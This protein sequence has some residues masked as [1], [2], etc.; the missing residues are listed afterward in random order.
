MVTAPCTRRPSRGEASR[1]STGRGEAGAHEPGP[2]WRRPPRPPGRVGPVGLRASSPPRAE[3]ARPARR[4]GGRQAPKWPGRRARPVKERRACGRHSLC[5]LCTYTTAPRRPWREGREA[6]GAEGGRG[7]GR[8]DGG[9]AA[10]KAPRLRLAPPWAGPKRG[11]ARSAPG[12]LPGRLAWG[13]RGA[14]PGAT[15]GRGP[16]PAGVSTPAAAENS[17]REVFAYGG[18]QG[19]IAP[20][21]GRFGLRTPDPA[22]W[23]LRSWF[24]IRN[25]VKLERWRQRKAPSV[26]LA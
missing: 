18:L 23:F 5:A 26:Y 22:R 25:S 10:S 12:H 14:G 13:R 7:E 19:W 9:R 17:C 15:E 3:R 4:A 24:C 8:S 11:E 20:E 2:G 21:I 6:K 16:Q 1:G